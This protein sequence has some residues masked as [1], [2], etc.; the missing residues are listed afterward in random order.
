MKFR[1]IFQP[2]LF[3]FILVPGQ[4]EMAAAQLMPTVW[5][6]PSASA[7]SGGNYDMSNAGG[8]AVMLEGFNSPGDAGG[9]M[10]TDLPSK[11][12]MAFTANA[13]GSKI[14]NS[15]TPFPAG[16]S[17]G[18]ALAGSVIHAHAI[19]SSYSVAKQTITMSFASST[20]GTDVAVT[21]TIGSAPQGAAFVDSGGNCFTRVS[22]TYSQKEWGAVS[23][24]ATDDTQALQ[25]WLDANQPHIAVAGNSII[26]N[27]L[28]CGGNDSTNTGIPTHDGIAI[29]GSPAASPGAN[30]QPTF[31]ISANDTLPMV[32][33]AGGTVLY[34]MNQPLCGLSAT[35]VVGSPTSHVYNIVDGPYS[36]ASVF[37]HS[38]L[39]GGIYGFQCGN[40]GSGSGTADAQVEDSSILNT[41]SDGIHTA[42]PNVKIQRN[43]IS[44]AGGDG[45][46]RRPEDQQRLSASHRQSAAVVV[47]ES[48]DMRNIF[49][50]GC[51]G[52]HGRGVGQRIKPGSVFAGTPT[53][54]SL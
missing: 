10:L 37:N 18:M 51:D 50:I 32:T 41:Y 15:V 23:D 11:A 35:G 26:S 21:T 16:L 7:F 31:L 27:T 24:G 19:V 39:Q 12:C 36:Q 9:G 34:Q 46:G 42:C 30:G 44:G 20:T 40:A 28:Y 8:G 54:P 13:D 3:C 48:G 43:V 29:Q 47:S 33:W 49:F 45:V 6:V 53:V 22:P 38:L 14:L 17:P 25:N 2:F 1:D 4:S 5:S 52:R